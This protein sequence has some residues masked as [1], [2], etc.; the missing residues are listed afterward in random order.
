MNKLTVALWVQLLETSV[1]QQEEVLAYI[2]KKKKKRG[3]VCDLTLLH[4]YLLSCSSSLSV[5][6]SMVSWCVPC[7]LH[8]DTIKVLPPTAEPVP[9]VTRK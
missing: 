8:T 1:G 7:C 4:C 9:L 6:C 5:S 3:M 2:E